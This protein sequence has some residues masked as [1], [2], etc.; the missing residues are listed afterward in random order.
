MNTSN[1]GDT[2]V[3][4]ESAHHSNLSNLSVKGTWSLPNVKVPTPFKT[5]NQGAMRLENKWS[6][7]LPIIREICSISG[8]PGL[9]LGIVEN[10]KTVYTASLG[11]VN[12]ESNIPC[13]INT[14][15]VLGS[16]SKGIIAALVASLHDDGTIS[17]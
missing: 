1:E 7:L 4:Y 3:I 13:D 15:F 6:A 9:S 14:T 11:Y 17:L 2:Q 12:L 8:I 16:L 5:L 10:N